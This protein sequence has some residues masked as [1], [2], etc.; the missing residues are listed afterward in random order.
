MTP[1]PGT[2]AHPRPP[3]QPRS[4]TRSPLGRSESP[5]EARAG[6]EGG[7]RHG[8]VR[9]AEAGGGAALPPPRCLSPPRPAPLPHVLHRPAAV[10]QQA[11]D[12]GHRGDRE[13]EHAVQAD[14][15]VELGGAAQLQQ[16]QRQQ[17]RRGQPRPELHGRAPSPDGAGLRLPARAPAACWRRRPLLLALTRPRPLLRGRGTGGGERG[18][19]AA[20]VASGVRVRKRLGAPRPRRPHPPLGHR[21]G[22]APAPPRPARD[23]AGALPP[24]LRPLALR[25]SPAPASPQR[26]AWAVAPRR[27]PPPGCLPTTCGHRPRALDR[28]SKGGRG[29]GCPCQPGC[30]TKGP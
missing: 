21:P 6:Q 23:T 10:A 9:E 14:L 13:A 30:H 20:G 27:S 4:P 15:G 1:A 8:K 5:G 25:P 24:G 22:A 16:Q 17:Q 29:R 11:D 7:K 19:G 26:V 12:H 28:G 3:P 2:P 18:G